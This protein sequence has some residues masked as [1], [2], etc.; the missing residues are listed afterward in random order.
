MR[1]YEFTASDG[2]SDNGYATVIIIAET[3]REARKVLQDHLFNFG[4]ISLYEIMAKQYTATKAP[5]TTTIIHS[6][7]QS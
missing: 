3:I 7:L 2:L 4:K 5:T 1:I 6:T